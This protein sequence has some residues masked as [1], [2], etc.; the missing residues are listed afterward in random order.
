M[1]TVEDYS[2]RKSKVKGPAHQYSLGVVTEAERQLLLDLEAEH[3]KLT[4]V[5]RAGVT[6]WFAT[7]ESDQQ[8]LIDWAKW[9]LAKRERDAQRLK[10]LRNQWTAAHPIEDPPPPEPDVEA[11]ENFQH[12][13]IRHFRW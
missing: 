11:I 8:Y 6:G 12:P 7:L 9:M 4:V 10:E 2:P 5:L 13:R 1:S 3:P